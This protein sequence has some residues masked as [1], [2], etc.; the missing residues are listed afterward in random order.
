MPLIFLLLLLVVQTSLSSNTFKQ[1]F[2]I[3][4]DGAGDAHHAGRT[5][6]G[7]Y[8][9]RGLTMQLAQ[10]IKHKLEQTYDGLRVILTRTPGESVTHIQK[11]TFANRIADLYISINLYAQTTKPTIDCYY[12]CFDPLAAPVAP[13]SSLRLTPLAHVHLPTTTVSQASAQAFC[14]ELKTIVTNTMIV[15]IPSGI[16][17][18]PLKGIA[19]PAFA[20]EASIKDVHDIPMLVTILSAA[21]TKSIDYYIRNQS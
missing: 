2:T 10:G 5:L 3:M 8:L 20:L 1:P 17:C 13:T 21:L 7:D 15:H 9:E 12:F 18:A 4:L 6:N 16:P 11:A 19:C 14:T